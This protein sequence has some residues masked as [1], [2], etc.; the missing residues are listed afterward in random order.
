M[1]EQGRGE[2]NESRTGFSSWLEPEKCRDHKNNWKPFKIIIKNN[3][4]I[5]HPFTYLH[6]SC[7][8]AEHHY[9]SLFCLFLFFN[10]KQSEFCV[11]LVFTTFCKN[12]LFE[13]T[14]LYWSL[15]EN[16][17]QTISAI[18][19]TGGDNI[20][21]SCFPLPLALLGIKT[22][23]QANITRGVFRHHKGL[24]FIKCCVL[25]CAL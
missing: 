17:L 8:A 25:A 4:K 7:T 21:A 11:N 19:F 9:D 16:S 23:S 24:I 1:T 5:S 2:R 14:I 15:V 13:W 12:N 3:L 20:S 18:F 10:K 22:R 6:P